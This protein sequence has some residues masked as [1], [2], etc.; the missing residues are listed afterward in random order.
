MF[1]ILLLLKDESSSAWHGCIVL[2][3]FISFFFWVSSRGAKLLLTN[4]FCS[5][6]LPT[7]SKEHWT[8]EHI[9]SHTS[10][11][12]WARST[13]KSQLK[14][15]LL[16]SGPWAESSKSLCPPWVQG[17]LQE[18]FYGALQ[19][20]LWRH[21]QKETS[22][23]LYNKDSV[24]QHSGSDL[25]SMVSSKGQQND[26]CTG[27]G[28]SQW[29][30]FV[31]EASLVK[32]IQAAGVLSFRLASYIINYQ[33]INQFIKSL[34]SIYFFFCFQSYELLSRDRIRV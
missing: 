1:S 3:K 32:I 16:L 2:K 28:H 22:I 11:R 4:S 25:S 24:Q 8:N 18:Q 13:Q 15:I 26:Q 14:E 20:A 12:K 17:V 30:G 29:A 23:D 10:K 6:Q 21:G 7:G 9:C 33:L 19:R 31:F 27:S 5:T 34:N